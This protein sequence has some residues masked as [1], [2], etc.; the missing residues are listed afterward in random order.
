M[1]PEQYVPTT[2]EEANKEVATYVANIKAAMVKFN[3]LEQSKV[4]VELSAMHKKI[5][6]ALEELIIEE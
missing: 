2:E 1:E 6:L 4:A 5:A 3:P